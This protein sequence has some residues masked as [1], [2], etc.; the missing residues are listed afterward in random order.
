MSVYSKRKKQS[1]EQ[2]A[3][4]APEKGRRRPRKSKV[5][6]EELVE[7]DGILKEAGYNTDW[8]GGEDAN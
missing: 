6:E 3:Q 2:Q 8:S 5:T 4:P 7:I 1:T